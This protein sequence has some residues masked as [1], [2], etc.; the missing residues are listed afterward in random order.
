MCVIQIHP[1]RFFSVIRCLTYQPFLTVHTHTHTHS[2]SLSLS[3]SHGKMIFVWEEWER[4]FYA[5]LNCTWNNWS[6][7]F[8]QQSTFYLF[9]PVNEELW[10]ARN[11][12]IK[13]SSTLS[14]CKSDYFNWEVSGGSTFLSL[15]EEKNVQMEEVV[16][17]RERESV[18]VCLKS[19]CPYWGKC[20]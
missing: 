3:P 10:G 16:G 15:S 4:K 7:E 17:G 6:T 18:C 14:E 5:G 20:V 11:L 1:C 8:E 9:W 13:W 12:A 2:L 19:R